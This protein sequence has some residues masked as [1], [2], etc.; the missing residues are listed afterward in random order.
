MRGVLLARLGRLSGGELGMVDGERHLGKMDAARQELVGPAGAVVLA[1]ELCDVAVDV[2]DLGLAALGEVL[3]HRGVV[4][5]VRDARDVLD[6]VE[7]VLAILDELDAGALAGVVRLL[8][9]P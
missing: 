5:R 6:V 3:I 2:V 9:L 7:L 4:Q 8:A 1:S